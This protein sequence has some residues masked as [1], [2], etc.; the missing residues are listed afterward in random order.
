M[1]IQDSLAAPA[2]L[3]ASERACL[4]FLFALS[5]FLCGQSM[6]AWEEYGL[7]SYLGV[8]GEV[9]SD[10]EEKKAGLAWSEFMNQKR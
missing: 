2:A 5:S 7:D 3:S 9:K 6:R 1:V 4:A 8:A 10:E